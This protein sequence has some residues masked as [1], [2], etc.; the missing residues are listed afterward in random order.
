VGT[1]RSYPTVDFTE[2]F[3]MSFTAKDFSAADRRAFLKALRLLDDDRHPSLR[4]HPL[5]GD[6]E[7]SW[8]ASAGSSLRM[9][10]ERLPGGRKRMLTCSRHYDR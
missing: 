7:G 5:R 10:F 4:V 3:L 6:R 8:S 9:T 1:D 2:T